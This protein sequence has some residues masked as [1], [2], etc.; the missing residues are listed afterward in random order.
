VSP[1]ALQDSG[2]KPLTTIGMV[3]AR[4]RDYKVELIGM[5]RY[6]DRET[7]RLRLPPL[8]DP[9]RFRLREMWVDAKSYSMLQVE[10]EG[11]F[12]D[13][14]PTKARWLTTFQSVNGCRVLGTETALSALDYG[15]N[16]KYEDT[17]I[18][19]SIT[20][21]GT[22]ADRAPVLTFRRPPDRNDVVEPDE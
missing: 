8:H 20:N 11:N 17:T 21:S 12:S 10:S 19:F 2:A 4:V 13:G 7:Y 5:D 1:P 15:R 9:A 6:E 3:Q 16:R 14:P 18:S 22:D